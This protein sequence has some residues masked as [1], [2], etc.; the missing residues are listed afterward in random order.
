MAGGRRLRRRDAAA[1]SVKQS[2]KTLLVFVGGATRLGQA[3]P[4]VLTSGRWTREHVLGCAAEVRC[5]RVE[6]ICCCNLVRT[7]R[8]WCT[9]RDGR[10]R[11]IRSS[12]ETESESWVELRQ[13]IEPN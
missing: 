7:P 1:D 3:P 11:A 9:V 10:R 4:G 5:R 12:K 13:L 8:K 6:H 2:I